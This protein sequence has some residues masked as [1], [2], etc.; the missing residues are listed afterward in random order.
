MFENM[1]N[2][3]KRSRVRINVKEFTQQMKIIRETN[4]QSVQQQLWQRQVP[5]RTA[6]HLPLVCQSLYPC[7][8]LWLVGLNADLSTRNKSGQDGYEKWKWSKQPLQQLNFDDKRLKLL[9]SIYLYSC[10][11]SPVSLQGV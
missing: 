3:E 5:H 7:R 2:S 9:F 11:S 10:S 4:H 8:C 6:W 1:F